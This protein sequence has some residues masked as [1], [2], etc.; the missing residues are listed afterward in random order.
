M[1]FKSFFL[2]CVFCFIA[3]SQKPGAQ[4]IIDKAIEVH[5][6]KRYENAVIEFDFRQ[7]HYKVTRK[8]GDF[9]YE[10]TFRDSTGTVHDVLTND[11]FFREV[12]G[13]RVSLPSKKQNSYIE[14]VNSVVYF[15][16][17]PYKL[18]DQAVNKKYVGESII[19]G[20]PYHQIEVS[21][22]KAGGGKDFKDVFYYWFH[23]NDFTLQYLAYS[24]GGQRFRDAYNPRVV[25]G[26]RFV[27][28]VNYENDS[29][30]KTPLVKYDSLF[31]AGKLRQLS[32]I[33]LKNIEVS[34]PDT[35]F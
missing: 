12:N 33:E 26:I 3:C 14:S 35:P 1:I 29:L 22:S 9:K 5:G 10:R 4:E 7:Y 23:A 11:N 18:N 20:I 15:A 13:E 2:L 17:L 31:E 25:N 19:K 21:F 8:G 30:E 32:R 28:Y 6:G 34:I 24:E 16:L 27:D